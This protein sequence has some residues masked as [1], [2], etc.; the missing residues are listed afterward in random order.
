MIHLLKFPYNGET[1]RETLMKGKIT[2]NKDHLC[3]KPFRHSGS[4]E[5]N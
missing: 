5:V 1:R 3:V 2:G 4:G